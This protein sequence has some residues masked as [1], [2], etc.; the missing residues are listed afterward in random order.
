[1]FGVMNR[2]TATIARPGVADHPHNVISMRLGE[3]THRKMRPR[4]LPRTF[5]VQF[6]RFALSMYIFPRLL[7]QT[8]RSFSLPTSSPISS[9]TFTY[10]HLLPSSFSK[11]GFSPTPVIVRFKMTDTNQGGDS[12]KKTYHKKATGNALT[13]VKNHSKEDDLKLYGS[14]FWYVQLSSPLPYTLHMTSF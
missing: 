11:P 6:N 13:T 10:H 3:L 14:A 12:S 2:A 4:P 9:K 7:H 1:M 5:V 8:S